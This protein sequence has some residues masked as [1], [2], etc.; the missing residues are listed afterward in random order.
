MDSTAKAFQ[1]LTDDH[2]QLKAIWFP[3]QLC[4]KTMFSAQLPYSR[5]FVRNSNLLLTTST[6]HKPMDHE[7]LAR[8]ADYCREPRRLLSS[9][10]L[11]GFP[12]N[13]FRFSK[14]VTGNNCGSASGGD[15]RSRPARLSI[16]SEF[17]LL[18]AARS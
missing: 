13:C 2:P 9:H 4:R 7:S 14:S 6:Y 1:Y 10:P 8:R 5:Q 15:S 11:C 3:H 16:Y 12:W 18:R 17:P